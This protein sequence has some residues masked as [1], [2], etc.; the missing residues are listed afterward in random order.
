M[1][2]KR[3][4]AIPYDMVDD[5]KG[6]DEKFIEIAEGIGWVWSSTD[7]FV[8]QWNSSDVYCF[9]DRE[10]SEL[11]IIE[12]KSMESE[13]EDRLWYLFDKW[14][15]KH[16]GKYYLFSFWVQ[17]CKMWQIGERCDMLSHMPKFV[18]DIQLYS[19]YTISDLHCLLLG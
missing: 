4:Y 13:I 19:G 17:R 2:E 18:G 6:S 12:V 1:S 8:R 7:E 9:P 11:R 15:E 14:N 3:V 10:F 16:G 5:V